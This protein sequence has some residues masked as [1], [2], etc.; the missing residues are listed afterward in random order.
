[1]VT[2]PLLK[3]LGEA[4]QTAEQG[5]GSLRYEGASACMNGMDT[6]SGMHGA[7][8]PHCTIWKEAAA[9]AGRLR[10]HHQP[11]KGW[12]SL[13]VLSRTGVNCSIRGGQAVHRVRGGLYSLSSPSGL[14]EIPAA[15]GHGPDAQPRG[16]AIAALGDRDGQGGADLAVHQRPGPNGA[17]AIHQ[18]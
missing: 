1:M 18:L 4:I 3:Q 9:G 16:E 12:L 6:Q 15:A 17:G 2:F 5:N 7:P 10:T 13:P 11:S 8:L 14:R